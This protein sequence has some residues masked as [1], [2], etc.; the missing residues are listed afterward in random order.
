MLPRLL[1]RWSRRFCTLVNMV[2]QILHVNFLVQF[3]ILEIHWE[4]G[5]EQ[6]AREINGL[7]KSVITSPVSQKL[8]LGDEE[9]VALV[10][11]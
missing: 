3:S 7:L 10:A 1:T 11:H 8:L 5:R 2:P 6:T 9:E 4:K